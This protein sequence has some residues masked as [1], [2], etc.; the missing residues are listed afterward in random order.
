[1]HRA[2]EIVYCLSSVS[3]EEKLITFMCGK[4]NLLQLS[5]CK[6][7]LLS[8]QYDIGRRE[9]SEFSVGSEIFH[10][11]VIKKAKQM[12]KTRYRKFHSAPLD[13]VYTI[14]MVM[15]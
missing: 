8:V 15:I 4:H 1:M 3:G 11:P 7:E 12:R 9:L 2:S 14:G 6:S 5:T 10:C 13:S